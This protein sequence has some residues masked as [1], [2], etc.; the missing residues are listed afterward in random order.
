MCFGFYI[1]FDSFILEINIY[2][3]KNILKCY[4]TSGQPYIKCNTDLL[5]DSI[6]LYY[7][8]DTKS[9]S[10]IPSNNKL[11][12]YQTAKQVPIYRK[13]HIDNLFNKLKE[14]HVKIN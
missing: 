6:Y 7:I 12:K 3:N 1:L 13:I 5:N 11:Y 4:S 2:P 10:P 9:F 8:T 14:L